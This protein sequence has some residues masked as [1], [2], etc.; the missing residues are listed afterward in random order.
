MTG[1]VHELLVFG[2]S[3]LSIQQALKQN[4]VFSQR[5]MQLHRNSCPVFS[6]NSLQG[7]IASSEVRSV[8]VPRV[9]VDRDR[10]TVSRKGR[11]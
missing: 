2:L 9:L 11:S 10:P 5:R 1:H 6:D 7:R 3:N 8:E 4:H